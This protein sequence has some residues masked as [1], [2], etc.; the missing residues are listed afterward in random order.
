MA[1]KAEKFA[2]PLL[3][4]LTARYGWWL[5]NNT[6][7]TQFGLVEPGVDFALSLAT[8]QIEV[9]NTDKD[10][11]LADAPSKAQTEQL[12]KHGGF[13]LLV[14]W[15]KGYPP[16][17]KGGDGYLVPWEA[18]KEFLRLTDVKG[19]STR[20]RSTARAFGADELLAPY[21]LD[22]EP[23]TKRG[24]DGRFVIPAEHVFWQELLGRTRRLVAQVKEIK[25]GLER[26][27][28]KERT[29][30]NPIE[31]RQPRPEVGPQPILP[32]S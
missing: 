13:I 29:S 20:R 26:H 12:D 15:D 3:S 7:M 14:M 10:G 23:G 9:K 6:D 22:W 17:P 16:L 11:V 24:K 4:D 31:T 1:G 25:S 27:D 19:K 5:K 28:A 30:G 21:K 8:I 32:G 18:Y 2:R